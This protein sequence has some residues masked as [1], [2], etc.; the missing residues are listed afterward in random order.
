[1]QK[2][3]KRA[4]PFLSTRGLSTGRSYVDVLRSFY[5]QNERTDCH[6]GSFT[7]TTIGRRAR[8][9]YYLDFSAMYLWSTR[10]SQATCPSPEFFPVVSRSSGGATILNAIWTIQVPCR[11]QSTTS[12]LTL[13]LVYPTPRIESTSSIVAKSTYLPT[14]T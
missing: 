4:K 10:K 11:V 7:S 5:P 12:P 3:N 8:A 14:K 2:N 13:N 1:M 9:S 6:N